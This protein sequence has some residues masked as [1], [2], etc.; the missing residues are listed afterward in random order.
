MLYL[1]CLYVKKVL[2]STAISERS[3]IHNKLQYYSRN[4]LEK[5]STSILLLLVGKYLFW[6]KFT[7]L[8]WNFSS[9]RMLSYKEL[10]VLDNSKKFP[11]GL[12]KKLVIRLFMYF[13]YILICYYYWRSSTW[14]LFNKNMKDF[15]VI[16]STKVL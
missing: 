6:Q 2:Y 14:S 9:W 4:G 1:L 13:L 3:H 8:N 7:I 5:L 15:S 12:K 11:L 16:S 10:I